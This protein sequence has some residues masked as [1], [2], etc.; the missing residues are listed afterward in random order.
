V[1]HGGRRY[2][3]GLERLED[4]LAPAIL[5]DGGVNGD[6][7]DWKVPQNWVGDVLPGPSDDAYISPE[8]NSIDVIISTNVVVNQVIS[9][10]RTLGVFDGG[11]LNIA[12]DSI[13]ETFAMGDLSTITGSGDLFILQSFQWQG[14]G[15][16]TGTG[17]TILGALCTSEWS[18]G[19][20]SDG[21]PPVL[22]RTLE[23]SGHIDYSAGIAESLQFDENG[24]LNNLADGM[25]EVTGPGRFTG[26]AGIDHSI[27]NAGTF[28]KT[29]SSTDITIIGSN[30]PFANSGTVEVQAGTLSLGGGGSA[31]GGFLVSAGAVLHFGSS[32][33]LGPTS[34]VTGA[35]TVE[36]ANG[37]VNVDGPVSVPIML[38]KPGAT[39]NLNTDI[40]IGVYSQNGG[41]LTGSGDL[42]VTGNFAITDDGTMSGSGK[43][44]LA[45]GSIGNW[46]D[47]TIGAPVLARTLENSGLLTFYYTIALF[48]NNGVV[49]NLADGTIIV[50][51]GS[52]FVA[53]AG[54]V[55]AINNAG[56]FRKHLES[57]DTATIGSNIPFTNSGTVEV[58]AGT[59]S[60]L[61]GGSAS[62]NFR[63]SAGAGLIFGSSYDLGPTSSVSGAGTV[64]FANGTVTVNGSLLV[65]IMVVE[66]GST[67]NLNTDV[68][69]G[70]YAL[71]GGT[72]T[73][74]GD[75]TVS[76]Q[77]FWSR[78]TMAG[79]G[80]T[81]LLPGASGTVA[82]FQSKYLGRLLENS[83]TLTYSGNGLW[84]EPEGRL[85]NLSNGIFEITGVQSVFMESAPGAH[86]I[87]NAGIFRK[88][89]SS[90]DLT[91]IF[92]SIPFTNTGTVE[93]LAGTLKLMGGG[94]ASG[95]FLVSDGA[96]LKFDNSYDLSPTSS[97][98]GAGTVV[99]AAGA[100]TVNGSV[101]VP[102]VRLNDATLTLNTDIQSAIYEQTYG[103]LTGAGD[104]SVGS[105]SQFIWSGGT[106]A[107]T[108]ETRLLP[109]ASGYISGSSTKTLG[110]LLE[111]SGTLTYADGGL[112]FNA[113][114][115]LYNSSNGVFEITGVQSGFHQ[116]E[117]GDHEIVNFGTFRKTASST[118]D[119]IIYP[120]IPFTNTGTVQ[121]QAGTLSIHGGG[122]ASGSFQVATGAVLHVSGLP[123][124]LSPTSSINGSGAIH[125][126]SNYTVTVDGSMSVPI[127][128]VF[129]GTLN[130]NTDIQPGIYEQTGST[131]TGSGDV[132]V[133]SQ[134]TWS[135]GVMA[136]TGETRL[137]PGASGTISSFNTKLLARL[138]Q[139][140]GTLTYADNGLW[141][142]PEG[143][144]HNLSNGGV[145]EIT[146]IQSSFMENAAGAHAIVNGG[147]FRKT[148]ASN[149]TTTINPNIPF[150]NTG[151]VEVQAGTLSLHGGGSASGS[152][153]VSTGATL[154]LA[155][156]TFA[157][158]G[159]ITNQGA[160]RNAARLFVGGD[161]GIG[162]LNIIGN[163]LQTAAGTLGMDL[164][165]HAQD[166]YDR[167]II[168]GIATL[169]GKLEVE[170]TS[171][172][173]PKMGDSFDIIA[174]QSH[175]G[176]FATINLPELGSG[177]K[178]N[179]VCGDQLFSLRI[180]RD[181]QQHQAEPDQLL[182]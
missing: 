152:F 131:L 159:T 61:G 45:A 165:F 91:T 177:F 76:S 100:I 180:I 65:P 166:Q 29:A 157:F 6:G 36:F 37:T 72:L 26:I 106:M 79:T 48:D 43:T 15:R 167:L 163:Y 75:V 59:L 160:F 117:A 74:T 4:R 53:L 122:S 120:T 133:S 63:V 46:L 111:N 107:G 1:A 78:G 27:H 156:G 113:G 115:E 90:T 182:P 67:V 139:N 84:F 66:L 95:S 130:L 138:L 96:V 134:F 58:Q 162:T 30:L 70:I 73:G 13:V 49:N 28:R 60:I 108:G 20:F 87:N 174:Y 129:G 125:F 32:Y 171:G 86:A 104:V 16:M 41:T 112:W 23:N 97:I 175:V 137:N 135:G 77:F 102:I 22:D 8:F 144:L 69:V 51:G 7:D 55:H 44:I 12:Y 147:T 81:R 140:S 47:S 132:T 168:T 80:E 85:H 173:V 161:G 89:A 52:D 158:S 39:V 50:K 94:S 123:Y 21:V 19:A 121:V 33:V 2:R 88:T 54:G 149:G 38:L 68:Q 128:R 98:S 143:R 145:F 153:Q 56:T 14:G 155:N 179:P 3:P 127:V 154:E 118:G 34:S 110:R 181:L 116:A 17:K 103:T 92:W 170:T 109:G 114:G 105:Q 124:L 83:G 119:S 24:F 141:F 148:A 146:G 57:T 99:F 10:A 150:T 5:W 151:T 136:G 126:N 172:F 31:T 11:S 178:L 64:E 71:D 25:I 93:V 169:D 176:C 82:G 42:T 62:G 18:D 35:G 101:S 142:D 9:Y 164:G 40:Q